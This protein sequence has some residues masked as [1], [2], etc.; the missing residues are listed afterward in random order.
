MCE[1]DRW[2]ESDDWSSTPI[3]KKSLKDKKAEIKKL[4]ENDNEL[5]SEIVVELRQ[6]KI[7][8]IRSKK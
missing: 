6:E 8:K 7:K 2:G 1:E 5:L 4:L 3:K